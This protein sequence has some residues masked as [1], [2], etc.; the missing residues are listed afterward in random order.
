MKTRIQLGLWANPAGARRRGFRDG[1]YNRALVYQMARAFLRV[2]I[3]G[4]R[5][6]LLGAISLL[7]LSIA[8]GAQRNI[9]RERFVTIAADSTP[10]VAAPTGRSASHGRRWATSRS[11][12]RPHTGRCACLLRT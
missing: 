5:G 12:S 10:L 3:P 7:F 11:R 4:I 6:A 1:L 2:R 8:A 9:N